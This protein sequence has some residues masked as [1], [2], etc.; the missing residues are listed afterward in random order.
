MAE[1]NNYGVKENGGRY[2][3]NTGKTLAGGLLV[4][5]FIGGFSTGAWT[6]KQMKEFNRIEK[7]KKEM[8][9][10][11]RT[12]DEF[13][14]GRIYSSAETHQ[15]SVKIAAKYGLPVEILKPS[16][17]QMEEAIEKFSLENSVK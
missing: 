10:E 8:M 9:N 17:E 14:M 7:I 12:F 2:L 5:Y 6:P 3:L 11:R 16:L 1:D 15:D 13:E 4:L